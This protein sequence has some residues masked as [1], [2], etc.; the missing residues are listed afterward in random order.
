MAMFGVIISE[1]LLLRD[2][3]TVHPEVKADVSTVVTDS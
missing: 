1:E 3:L 2:K